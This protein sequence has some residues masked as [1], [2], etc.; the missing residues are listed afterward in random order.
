MMGTLGNLGGE[1]FE[2]IPF[3]GSGRRKGWVVQHLH[4]RFTIMFFLYLRSMGDKWGHEKRTSGRAF[5][6]IWF[7]F[8]ETP[9]T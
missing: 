2:I 1:S 3:H 9:C 8:V 4:G 5:D 7:C 6:T